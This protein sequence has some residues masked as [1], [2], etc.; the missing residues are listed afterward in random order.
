MSS[1]TLGCDPVE[2][3]PGECKD[4]A[5][6]AMIIIAAL[7]TEKANGVGIGLRNNSNRVALLVSSLLSFYAIL[8]HY[9]DLIHCKGM[10]S[11]R[12]L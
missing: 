3:L 11:H 8:H 2:L 10:F 7:I 12:S 6:E 9:N 5:N 1:E 4:N